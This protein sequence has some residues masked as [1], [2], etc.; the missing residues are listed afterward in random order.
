MAPSELGMCV[1]AKEKAQLA[2]VGF[3]LPEDLGFSHTETFEEHV[4]FTE[5]LK[6]KCV[7][8]RPLPIP[9]VGS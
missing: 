5:K 2:A 1:W 8:V 3:P 7:V 6:G 4:C 9:T